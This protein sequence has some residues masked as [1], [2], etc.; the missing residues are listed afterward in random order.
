MISEHILRL[1][2]AL[3]RSER[4]MFE[5]VFIVTIVIASAVIVG[6]LCMRERAGKRR[7]YAFGFRTERALADNRS[8]K[9]ANG[10]CG[11]LWVISGAAAL[12]L[13]AVVPMF[14][15]IVAGE[16]AG[17]ASAWAVLLMLIAAVW[18]SVVIVE[19]KLA[20]MGGQ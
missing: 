7:D 17:A 16:T 5:P 8:W 15:Y 18:S 4:D 19:K 12:T 2:Q 3:K 20:S 14:A 13:S 10:L 6:G 11:R 1:F 9:L